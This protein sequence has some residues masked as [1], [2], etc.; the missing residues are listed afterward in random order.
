MKNN[1]L[2]C[3]SFVPNE[4]EA[5][6]PGVSSAGN[7]FQNNLMKNMRKIGISVEEASFLGMP[8]EDAS[9][10]TGKESYVLKERNIFKSILNYKKLVKNK[11]SGADTVIC[12]NIIYAWLFL[13]KLAKQNNVRSIAIIADYSE[14]DSY[15]SIPRKCYVKLQRYCMRRFDT[16]VGLSAN[17]EKQLKKGQKF[18]L[19]EGGIDRDFYDCFNEG[20][21]ETEADGTVTLM[22][23]GLLEPVTGVD[24]FLEVTK[25]LPED[26]RL[27]F[28]FTGKGSISETIKEAAKTDSRIDFKGNMEYSDYIN[29]LKKADILINPRNMEL[30]ENRNNFPSKVLDY[31]ATGRRV[32]ST[33][34][35]GWEK[36]TDCFDFVDESLE[37]AVVSVC[38]DFLNN[39][40]HFEQ[41]REFAK[42]FV[43]DEQIKKILD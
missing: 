37:E 25:K 14:E 20:K 13:P 15:N 36:F 24:K 30:P 6:E 23:S 21:S 34:F 33:K 10:F 29:E 8:L 41:N 22:Y 17:I 19:L 5:K 7:R 12:Y 39:G 40:F 43:W 42:Q 3:G 26:M 38:E 31:L 32:I 27:R 2:F 18:I 9:F 4:V 16:V 1:I 28:V 11:L 35:V